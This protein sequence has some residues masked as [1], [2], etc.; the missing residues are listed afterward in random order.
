MLMRRVDGV[1]KPPA[2]PSIEIISVWLIIALLLVIPPEIAV[3]IRL[4]RIKYMYA[5]AQLAGGIAV[6]PTALVVI[7]K[8]L[9]VAVIL[10]VV[11]LL[12]VILVI[13]HAKMTRNAPQ[14]KQN[15]LVPAEL[16]A[17]IGNGTASIIN[18]LKAIA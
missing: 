11:V 10:I 12:F 9:H 2:Q 15:Y 1:V 16:D 5:M 17:A 13:R 14:A 8:E 7:L 18:G 4:L 6:P 3:W